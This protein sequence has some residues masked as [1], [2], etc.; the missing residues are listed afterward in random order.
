M[1]KDKTLCEHT[2]GNV[3]LVEGTNDCH[4]IMN[5]CKKKE[6]EVPRTFGLYACGSDDQV[7]KRFDALILSSDRPQELGIVLDADTG[8]DDRWKAIRAK[9][10][11]YPYDFPA[12]PQPSGTIIEAVDS[13]P[14]L[15]VWL[16]PNNRDPG[17]LEDFCIDMIEEKTME[18]ARTAVQNAKTAGVSRFRDTH[19]SKA[20]ITPIWRGRTSRVGHLAKPSLRKP[21]ATIPRRLS[22]SSIG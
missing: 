10:S 7:L 22:T 2:V 13:C 19:F 17:I 14:K 1:P 18:I 6:N 9:L 21:Y 15:G 3:L 20:V 16:M 12:Q 8:V 4:V 5:L 11:H